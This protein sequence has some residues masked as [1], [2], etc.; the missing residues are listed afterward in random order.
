MKIAL[1]ICCMGSGG[2]GTLIR[3]LALYLREHDHKVDVILLDTPTD[4]EF[5]LTHTRLLSEAG[6]H[7]L[8][9]GRKPHSFVSATSSFCR[10]WKQ[11]SLA[12]YDIIHTNSQ[13]LHQIVGL[14]Q[15]TFPARFAQVATVHN[16]RERW[17]RF[18][19]FLAT[20]AAVVY[21]SKAAA[22]TAHSVKK[23]HIIANGAKVSTINATSEQVA[24]LRHSLRV[25]DNS[26]ILLSVGNLRKQ[27]NYPLALNVIKR[28]CEKDVFPNIQYLICG[29]GQERRVLENEI[30]RLNLNGHV[31]L[32]GVRSDVTLLLAMT[33][34]YLSTSLHEG[35]PMAVLEAF[36]SGT[37]CVLSPI[38]EHQDISSGVA[39][40]SLPKD[41][42]VDAFT[43]ALTSTIALQG[44]REDF[45]VQRQPRLKGFS[46]EKMASSYEQLYQSL[47]K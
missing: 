4:T 30:D 11:Q 26:T 38:K 27:K 5:E 34:C 42:T 10:L 24:Q 23:S 39:G 19:R 9:L 35:L 13:L 43:E 7:V 6:I 40:C 8:S 12:K 25:P 45:I 1:V 28:L 17:G 44:S 29:E 2:S 31:H 14:F 47:L 18:T 15:W 3:D 32:L 33:N 46:F 22:D 36:F 16:T 20:K 41:M 21:C 37:K